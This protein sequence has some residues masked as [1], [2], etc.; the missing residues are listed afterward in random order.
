MIDVVITAEDGSRRVWRG[1]SPVLIGR[2]DA[3]PIRVPGWRV[4][5]SHARLSRTPAG[6]DIEDLGSLAGTQV[7]AR[8]ITR[9]GPLQPDD[10]IFIGGAMLQVR[11][12]AEAAEAGEVYAGGD[13]FMTSDHGGVD[14]PRD[15]VPTRDVPEINSRQGTM[16]QGNT[17]QA[18]DAVDQDVAH[19]RKSLLAGKEGVAAPAVSLTQTRIVHQTPDQ[20]LPTTPRTDVSPRSAEIPVPDVPT[21]QIAAADDLR[22]RRRLH[23]RLLDGLDLRRRDVSS[24]SDAVL[25]EEAGRL[26]SQLIETDPELPPDI[27]RNVLRQHVLDEAV[28]LGPLEG[29][30]ADDA[31]TEIMVNRFD[32]IF[33]ERSGKLRRHPTGFSSERA[34]LGVI[35]RIVAPLGRRIDESSPMVDA[36]LRDGSR[37]NAVIAPVALRGASLTIRKF[38]KRRLGIEDLIAVGAVD[39]AM[40]RFLNCCVEQRCNVLVSGGTGSGKT[41]LLNVLSNFIPLGERIVTIEDAAE[42]RLRHPHLVSLES[43]PANLEGR[44]AILI[45]DLVR[46]ALRMRP[47]RIVIGECRGAEALDMLQAM[48]TGHEGSLTTLHANTPRDAI[49]RLETLVLMAGMDLP[50]TAIREQIASAID[51]VIQQ[52]RASDGRRRIT[53]IVELTGMESGRIQ[54]QELFRFQ[55]SRDAASPDGLFVGCG[56][57]PTMFTEWREAGVDIDTDLFFGSAPARGARHTL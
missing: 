15:T 18:A 4:A 10:E 21:E 53:S 1:D 33:V 11:T 35:E 37:V 2:S 47:D 49:A 24:M 14:A 17:R 43:R 48:N 22:W 36:R 31:V 40:A 23:S 27:D 26:L 32:E 9:Y 20:F 12:V 57:I 8:R 41:T 38:S 30:L 34:V 50:L 54:L 42:L 55:P 28:G 7:N 46:N 25:R 39:T 51:I 16:Q 56:L 6:V 13:A 44:G 52:T 5:R 45:R 19:H 3:C 29:L